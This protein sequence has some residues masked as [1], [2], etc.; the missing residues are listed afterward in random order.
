MSERIKGFCLERKEKIYPN[1]DNVLSNAAVVEKE[2]S[3]LKESEI[4]NKNL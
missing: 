4:I 2:T 1:S 3:E